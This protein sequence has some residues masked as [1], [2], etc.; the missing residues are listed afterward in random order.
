MQA[1]RLLINQ[2]HHRDSSR[3]RRVRTDIVHQVI[4]EKLTIGGEVDGI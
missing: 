2:S 1:E 4:T 3:T